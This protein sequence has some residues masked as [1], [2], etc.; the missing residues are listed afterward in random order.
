M[1]QPDGIDLTRSTWTNPEGFKQAPRP[2]TPAP[3]FPAVCGHLGPEGWE[4]ELPPGHRPADHHR[5]DDGTPQGVR[6][7]Q[8]Y[9]EVTTLA[10]A[11]PQYV[12]SIVS[13]DRGDR[14]EHVAA[15]AGK[16]L[17]SQSPAAWAVALDKILEI[18]RDQ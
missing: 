13:L 12:P 8:R 4:C 10:D 2:S 14:L 7:T 18:C 16:A 17:D 5:A 1:S 6:W 3:P 11:E 9:A 15:I